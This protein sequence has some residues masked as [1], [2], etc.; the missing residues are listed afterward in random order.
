MLLLFIGIEQFEHDVPLCNFLCF[1]HFGFIEVL[2]SVGLYFSANLKKFCLL[3]LQIFFSVPH[4][5]FRDSI[6]MYIKLLDCL[7]FFFFNS[8]LFFYFRL[9]LVILSSLI[10][11]SQCLI[12]CNFIQYVI[13]LHTVSSLEIRVRSFCIFNVSIS[14][15]EGVKYNYNNHSD[16][17]DC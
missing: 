16:A 11:S 8:F 1:L 6:Y 2:G 4:S 15:F 3:C 5:S 12:C 13:V 10:F 7:C 14:L 9:F 17:F